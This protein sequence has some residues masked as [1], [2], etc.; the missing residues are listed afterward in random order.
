MENEPKA[1]SVEKSTPQ[2]ETKPS[3]PNSIGEMLDL[4]VGIETTPDSVY[5]T[6]RAR[7]A[8][9]DIFASGVVRN[10]QSA[11]LVNNGRWGERVFW[12]RGGKGKHI[13][14]DQGNYVV[15]APT[16]VA[17]ERLVTKEDLRSIYTRNETN[18]IVNILE[19]E[20]A[21]LAQSKNQNEAER[22]ARIEKLKK[23]LQNL[24]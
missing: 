22:L 12:S 8:I 21:K 20:R 16:Q 6:L 14:V 11:G 7:E 10:R 19:E 24:A 15:E 18:E 1:E 9:D 3:N 2:P 23:E 4:K 13:N 17:E 5:R